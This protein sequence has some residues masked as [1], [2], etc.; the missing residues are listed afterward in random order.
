MSRSILDAADLECS[1]RK[2]GGTQRTPGPYSVV[3]GKLFVDG[4][5]AREEV[6]PTEAARQLNELTRQVREQHAAYNAM[7]DKAAAL[8]RTVA[9]RHDWEVIDATAQNYVCRLCHLQMPR[10]S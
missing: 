7:L 2:D 3:N 8:E 10:A 9:C 4:A 6:R 1:R 5:T